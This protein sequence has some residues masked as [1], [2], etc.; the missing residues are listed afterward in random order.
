MIGGIAML[1]RCLQNHS[2]PNGK[3]GRRYVG[4]VL[5][6]GYPETAAICGRCNAPGVV[7]LD[8][9]EADCYE[10]GERIF[11]ASN[12]FTKIKVVAGGMVRE[13]R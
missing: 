11:Q 10:Q 2:W 1:C 8:E 3:N 7:W 4:Y 13:N 12:A 9:E 6:I 5:P